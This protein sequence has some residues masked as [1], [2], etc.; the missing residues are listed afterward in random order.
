MGEGEE[1][2]EKQKRQESCKNS[3][4]ACIFLLC[5]SRMITSVVLND[6]ILTFTDSCGNIVDT[7]NLNEKN[8]AYFS[9][10]TKD[11]RET[12]YKYKNSTNNPSQKISTRG[13]VLMIGDNKYEISWPAE[14]EFYRL[15][16]EWVKTKNR[17]ARTPGKPWSGLP[18]Y[19]RRGRKSRKAR[20]T[21]KQRKTRTS[22]K[23]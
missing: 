14:S 15:M 7:F 17:N 6:G 10:T 20:Q 12:G 16:F 2:E 13:G 11:P 8:F 21:R 18:G 4:L 9:N 22:R 3:Y 5:L 19:E 1:T 23:I